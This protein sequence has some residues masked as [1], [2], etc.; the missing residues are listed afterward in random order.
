MSGPGVGFD[1]H[2]ELVVRALEAIRECPIE[3]DALAR[4][5]FGLRQAPAGLAS[6]L[7]WE[8]LGS[9]RRVEVDGLGVWRPA[10]ARAPGPDPRIAELEFAVVDVETTGGSPAHG[11]RVVEFACVRVRGGEVVGEYESLVDPCLAIPRWIT[12]LTGIDD[13]MVSGAPRFAAIAGRVREE[14]A[15]RVFVAHNAA[16]D[17]RF[18]SEELRLA[19]SELPAG[20]RLCTV[21]LARRAAPGLRRRG[22]DSLARFYDVSI[23][24]RHR[25]AGDA[26][27]TATILV[28]ML[29]EA[30]RQGIETWGQLDAWLAGR[31][32]PTAARRPAR[33]GTDG[34]APCP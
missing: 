25:A 20:E 33:A 17:W 7:V 16:F 9:D 8:L 10:D 6:R 22:L 11:D 31:P 14:L 1:R 32:T 30:G 12:R 19:R 15:G 26:R 18:V 3:T 21:R 24:G 29:D 5:V 13:G 2:S 4:R 34:E 23:D 27:A 28:R